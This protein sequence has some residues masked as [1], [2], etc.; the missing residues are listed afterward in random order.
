MENRNEE[1]VKELVPEQLEDVSGGLDHS[2][3]VVKLLT[4]KQCGATF[5]NEITF[6][7]H[8][9]DKHAEKFSRF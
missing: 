1:K 3:L 8:K 5:D 7:N 4:C 9:R 6:E 2:K